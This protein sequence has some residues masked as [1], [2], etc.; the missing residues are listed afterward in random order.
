VTYTVAVIL[1]VLG[2]LLVDLALLRTRLVARRV[3]WATYAVVFGFQLLF[4]GILT[5]RGVVRYDE[6]A[7]LGPRLVGAPVEDI[8]FGFALVLTTLALWTWWGRREPAVDGA[9]SA[10][11]G[12]ESRP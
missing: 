6:R 4:N 12:P 11:R 3:F 1:G 7:I 10:G 2:A 8:A 9:T 5:S